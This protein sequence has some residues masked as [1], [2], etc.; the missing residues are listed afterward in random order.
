MD[1]GEG[2][3]ANLFGDYGDEFADVVG[4]LNDTRRHMWQWD[5]SSAAQS[6]A[7]IHYRH[8]D[9]LGEARRTI[10][11]LKA[12]R[13]GVNTSLEMEG[14]GPD[15][16]TEELDVNSSD[17][18]LFRKLARSRK[19]AFQEQE[20]VSLYLF[21]ELTRE[22]DRLAEHVLG[23][24]ESFIE[25]ESDKEHA[26]RHLARIVES[27]A[28]ALRELNLPETSH[29]FRYRV[30]QSGP[31]SVEVRATTE[32]PLKLS[33][34]DVQRRLEDLGQ[35]VNV[36]GEGEEDAESG[37]DSLRF[38]V[39]GDSALFDFTILDDRRVQGEV[40]PFLSLDDLRIIDEVFDALSG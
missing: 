23:V 6:L 28:D 5:Y 18:R 15:A 4:R 3:S 34:E 8:R 21:G 7:Q 29:A 11:Q 38:R 22:V 12:D 17:E 36:L 1:T 27:E 14:E 32:Y 26:L 10:E 35:I 24:F 40:F 33:F 2:S 13:K 39:V 20:D 16:E 31:Q 9:I 19:T 37:A 25:V 30:R